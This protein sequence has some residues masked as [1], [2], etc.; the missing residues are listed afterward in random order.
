MR[1][2][3]NNTPSYNDTCALKYISNNM[4]N[5]S[6]HVQVFVIVLSFMIIAVHFMKYVMAVT[7]MFVFMMFVF[8]M[9]V[10]VMFMMLVMFMSMSMPMPMIVTMTYVVVIMA[11]YKDHNQIPS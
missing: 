8:M 11:K 3:V 6:S 7:I 9:F 5:C 4:K 2:K 1:I 10:V